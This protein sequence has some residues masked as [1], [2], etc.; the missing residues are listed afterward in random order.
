M[1]KKE[2]SG[3]ILFLDPDGSYKVCSFGGKFLEVN[4]YE[5]CLFC[6]PI[7]L[8][9]KVYLKQKALCSGYD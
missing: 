2:A 6:M 9:L 7:I 4:I 5:L 8:Q 1:G 3:A